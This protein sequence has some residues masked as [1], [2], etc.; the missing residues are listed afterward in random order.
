MIT[1]T[2]GTLLP[3]IATWST[4]AVASCIFN[5]FKT[6]QC[7]SCIRRTGFQLI[8]V[9]SKRIHCQCNATL[10][11]PSRSLPF[12]V[13]AAAWMNRFLWMDTVAIV[14]YVPADCYI[15]VVYIKLYEYREILYVCVYMM[16][17]GQSSFYSKCVI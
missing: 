14:L 12:T 11:L 7:H 8:H 10:Y 1:V 5:C 3:A 4:K 2:G 9:N 16:A 17:R 15:C 6:K 13:V